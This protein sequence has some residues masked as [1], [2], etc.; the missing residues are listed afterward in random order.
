MGSEMCI[1]DSLGPREDVF[2]FSMHGEKNFPFRKIASDLDVGLPDGTTDDAYIAALEKALPT[3]LAFNPDIILYQA[4]VDPLAEDSLGRM[5]LTHQGLMQRDRI[6]FNACRSNN[7][8]VS[9]A[10]G[11]GYAKPIEKTV[12]AYVNTYR[13]AKEIYNFQA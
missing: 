9:M 3:A 8:P 2:V 1:R 4:G 6:I 7:I 10:I 12:E 13:A 5:N 11:G